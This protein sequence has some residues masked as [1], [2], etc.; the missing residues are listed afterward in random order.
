MGT[1]FALH[2]LSDHNIDLLF[3]NPPLIWLILEPEEPT[4]YLEEIKKKNQPSLLKKLFRFKKENM[5]DEISQPVEIPELDFCEGENVSEDLDK[6]WH[7]IH[8]CMTLS[9]ADG[10]A[11]RDFIMEDGNE[12]GAIEVGYGPA[13]AYN[14]IEVK[15]IQKTLESLSRDEFRNNYNPQKM[16]QLGIYPDIW[17][18]EQFEALEYLEEHY[19]NLKSFLSHCVKHD[20]GMFVYFC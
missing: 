16:H 12:I 13:R 8:Y 5:Q 6:A 15:N 9:E 19:N 7:G 10:K 20:L 14:S 3:S 4:I 18:S 11:H 1:C 17:E 2:S